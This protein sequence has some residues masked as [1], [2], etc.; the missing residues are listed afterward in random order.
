MGTPRGAAE[1]SPH[2]TATGQSPARIPQLLRGG[3][4]GLRATIKYPALLTPFLSTDKIH[5]KP[6]RGK[7][8]LARSGCGCC[9][10]FL[11][12]IPTGEKQVGVRHGSLPPP[13]HCQKEKKRKTG[14]H[15]PHPLPDA[16]E[17]QIAEAMTSPTP[18]RLQ[19][20]GKA[21]RHLLE[22]LLTLAQ[23]KDFTAR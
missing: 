4:G 16:L 13:Q 20:L 12:P 9:P 11:G 6:T 5:H 7:T 19:L 21:S 23:S 22:R 2:R 17:L 15:A 10:V 1:D 3:G 18:H 14:A 8:P